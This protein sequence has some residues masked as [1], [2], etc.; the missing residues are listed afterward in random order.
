[1]TA[2]TRPVPRESNDSRVRHNFQLDYRVE[3]NVSPLRYP[4]TGGIAGRLTSIVAPAFITYHS[5]KKKK[6]KNGKKH[7]NIFKLLLYCFTTRLFPY[8][9][10]FASHRV[11]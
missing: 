9:I 10:I 7:T 3:L 2:P 8:N 1:M 6:K 11:S 4:E 5:A